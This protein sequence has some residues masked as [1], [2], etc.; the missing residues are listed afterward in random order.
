MYWFA[1]K[2]YSVV[3]RGWT[4][5]C[6]KRLENCWLSASEICLVAI[7]CMFPSISPI[8][9]L[10]FQL[11]FPKFLWVFPMFPLVFFSVSYLGFMDEK[12]KIKLEQFHVSLW[13]QV[14]GVRKTT[15]NI[16]VLTKLGRLP[17]K[18]YIEIQMFKY[19]QRFPFLEGNT[20]LCI[21]WMKKL[22]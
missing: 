16:Q 21:S 2:A 12:S 13:K 6:M 3:I 19:L 10:M 17:F 11:L 9:F 20:Y 1:H 7:L 22:K 8:R 18:I 15:S 4:R 14:L 5:F